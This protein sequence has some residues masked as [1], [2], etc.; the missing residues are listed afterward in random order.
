MVAVPRFLRTVA[1][2]WT[3]EP[4]ERNLLITRTG[5]LTAGATVAQL[6]IRD[7]FRLYIG[8]PDLLVTANGPRQHDWRSRG[9]FNV[10]GLTPTEEVMAEIAALPAD[11]TVTCVWYQP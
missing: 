2:E 6:E 8:E 11:T 10:G 7:S 4:A 5:L 9:Y 3:E 1:S